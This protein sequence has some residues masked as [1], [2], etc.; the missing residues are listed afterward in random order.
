MSDQI[1]LLVL[2]RQILRRVEVFLRESRR[3]V[4]PETSTRRSFAGPPRP[5]RLMHHYEGPV[6][7]P[8]AV[9]GITKTHQE[10]RVKDQQ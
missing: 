4:I 8:F 7:R 2:C 9:S 6:I 3:R 10:A 1:A 5:A